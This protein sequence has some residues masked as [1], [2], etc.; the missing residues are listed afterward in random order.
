MVTGSIQVKDGKYYAVLNLKNE[1]GKRKQKWINTGYTIRGNKK[2]AEKFLNE[3]IAE[4]DKKNIRYS[5]LT[6]ADY[7]QNWLDNI[8]VEVKPNTYRSYH[9]NMVNHIIPYFKSKGILLQDL[10]PYQLEDYY[11]YKL[12]PNSKINSPEALS[13]TTIKHHHQNI[14]KALSDA[15]R[16]GILYYNPAT[17]A[18]TPKQEKFKSEF[19][20]PEQIN[21]MLILFKDSIVYM[22]VMLCAVY[23]LRRS[24]ALG[25]KWTHIDFTS[26]SIRICETLQQ[27]TGGSYTDSTKT[28]S[29]NR[30]LPMT[31]DVYNVLIKH[32]QEQKQRKQLMGNYYVDSDFV[33]TW[34]NGKVITPNYLT[35]TFHSVISKSNLPQIR[36]HDL[37]HSCASNLISN[38]KSVVEV[39]AWLGHSSSSTTLN[40]YA[41]ADK[42]S[43]QNIADTLKTM[44]NIT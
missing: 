16:R 7:F 20:N 5:D 44:I 42:T 17:S 37:R 31:D 26:K 3:K 32:K 4:W 43:K 18:R 11:K 30:T 34:N 36:L 13:T 23:G 12:K 6:V 15:V 1:D 21:E 33:C 38:G 8:K 25:L 10:K 22:P 9:G 29:S 41:H 14:S 27:H 39:A 24:E 2:K 35:K 19:L 28:E 40:V